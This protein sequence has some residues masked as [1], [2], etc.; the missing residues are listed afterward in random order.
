MHRVAAASI[1]DVTP[2]FSENFKT[3]CVNAFDLN[4]DRIFLLNLIGCISSHA[5]F[6]FWALG[7]FHFLKWFKYHL[8]IFFPIVLK[9]LRLKPWFEFDY[10]N[11]FSKVPDLKSVQ[12]VYLNLS[13]FESNS[14]PV[15]KYL[16]LWILNTKALIKFKRN[17]SAAYH[18]FRSKTSSWPVGFSWFSS[19]H[20]HASLAFFGPAGPPIPLSSSNQTQQLPSLSIMATVQCPLAIPLPCVVHQV[21]PRH[22]LSFPSSAGT[23]PSPLRVHFPLE[24]I[25]IELHQATNLLPPSD[26]LPV[27]TPNAGNQSVQRTPATRET[28]PTKATTTCFKYGQKGHYANRCPNR[29]Q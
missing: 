1:E 14:N 26:R 9:V 17:F 15:W 5:Y 19:P 6:Y 7:W 2:W 13:Q 22:F 21:S 20:R 10:S 3:C 12:K 8:V 29:H 11:Q 18:Q 23:A 16:N 24:I 28:L 27:Q 4:S 25:G